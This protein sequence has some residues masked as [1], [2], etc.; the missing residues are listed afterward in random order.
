MAKGHYPKSTIK[1]GKLLESIRIPSYHADGSRILN[2]P[3]LVKVA[4][5][6]GSY[7]DHGTG[8]NA[9]PA[10]S[11]LAALVQVSTRTVQRVLATLERLGIIRATLSHSWKLHRPTTWAFTRSTVDKCLSATLEAVKARQTKYWAKLRAFQMSRRPGGS[12]SGGQ[13]VILPSPLKGGR[14]RSGT[15]DVRPNLE[16]PIFSILSN[17]KNGLLSSAPC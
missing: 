3:T 5:V 13:G 14:E 7:T 11:T 2:R 15:D 1:I 10:L 12:S 6:L 8:E 4:Q 16:N 9:R 17:L